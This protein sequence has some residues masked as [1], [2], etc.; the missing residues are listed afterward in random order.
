MTLCHH[1]LCSQDDEVINIVN[2]RA[3]LELQPHEEWTVNEIMKGSQSVK[4]SEREV[5]CNSS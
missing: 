4:S 5:D 3:P 2:Y 1:T